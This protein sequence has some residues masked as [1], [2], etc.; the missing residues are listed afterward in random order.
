MEDGIVIEDVSGGDSNTKG[1]QFV[2]VPVGK[3]QT[4]N[5]EKEIILGRYSF[6][7][8]GKPSAYSGFYK[9]ET[10]SEH[11]ETVFVNTVAKDIEDFLYK[12]NLNGGYYIGRY[13]GG[14]GSYGYRYPRTSS[15]SDNNPIVCKAGVYPY[16]YITQQQAA[17]L[18]R[19]MY[20]SSNFTSD[21]INSYAWD[22]AIFFI[23]ECN[24]DED[25]SVQN[26][27]QDTIA[28]CGEATDGTNKDERC[29]IFDMAGN[30][31]EWSTETN[32]NTSPL[33]PLVCRGGSYYSSD[34]G[35]TT[36]NRTATLKGD[37]A[38]HSCR[39]IL[40]L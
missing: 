37:D 12:A 23:Q 25:Y 18:C 4:T 11:A 39:P 5:G 32:A 28:K 30:T 20:N 13:E 34:S 9:E 17:T 16:N 14:D 21:L 33:L 40:Y 2:W 29:N 35:V 7:S 6:D 22:T 8:E 1:S 31:R 10:P 24:K 38:Y 36:S 15:T 27:L 19:D 3:I 26:R